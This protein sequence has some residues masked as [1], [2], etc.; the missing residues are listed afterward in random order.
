[1]NS[2]L[3]STRLTLVPAT[4]EQLLERW[5]GSDG[6]FPPE[7]SPL[8][9][10]QLRM[11]RGPDPWLLGYFAFHQE[12]KTRI[13]SGGFKGAPGADGVV[14]IA[15]G[16]DEPHRGLGYATE[17]AEALVTFAFADSRVRLICAH[18][19]PGATASVRVLAKCGFTRVPDVVDPEDGPVWRFERGRP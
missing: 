3:T 11:A 19:A 9:I 14:E 17:V 15:Y 6:T 2:T 18:T 12:S 13:G 16:I 10:E 1:M 5:I 4:P 7:V 8:W